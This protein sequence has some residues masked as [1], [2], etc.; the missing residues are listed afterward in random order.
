MKT[1]DNQRLLMATGYYKGGIDGDRGVKTMAAVEIIERTQAAQYVRDPKKWGEARR[2]IAAGQAILNVYGFEAGAVD[3]LSGHNTLEAFRAWDYKQTSGKSERVSRRPKKGY[4]PP[5]ASRKGVP[6]QR[7]VAKYYGKPGA[8]IEKQL[9]SID[10]PYP[11]RLDWDLG[12]KARTLRIHKKAAPS[13]KAALTEALA[14]YGAAKLREL[15]LDRYAG[16]HNH[17]KMRGGKK[18]S[19]HAYGCAIDIYAR[20]NGLRMKCPQALFCRPEYKPFLDIMEKHGWH[21][22]IRLWGKDAMH[23]QRALL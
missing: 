13:L 5:K 18:W 2:L 12:K 20:P 23:F 11:M 16:G 19:M 9:V 22:A 1:R 17:R 15:G 14:V 4:V 3:G 21:P 8:Q 7:D 10:A 6:H